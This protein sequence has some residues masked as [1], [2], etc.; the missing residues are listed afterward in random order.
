MILIWI[1]ILL[2]VII[3][4]YIIDKSGVIFDLS[5]FIYNL[6]HSTPWMYKTIRKPFGCAKCMTLWL[7]LLYCLFHFGVIMSLF[8]AVICSSIL[9]PIISKIYDIINKLIDRL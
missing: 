8:I 9:S 5:K 1:N 6:T 3:V 2:I 4:T 7:V